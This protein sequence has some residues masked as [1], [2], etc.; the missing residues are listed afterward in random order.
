M[1]TCEGPDCDVE[2][3]P[4]RSTAKFCSATCRK[5]A[6]R[7]RG[8][9]AAPAEDEAPGA[10][11]GLTA[12]VR[13]E[14]IK[15]GALDTFYG[16]LAVQLARRL[17]YPDE[18]GISALSKELRTVMDAAVKSVP[19]PAPEAASHDAEDEVTKARRQR[20]ESRK[21]AGLA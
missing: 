18:S 12:S 8:A 16:Q 19:E 11:D 7:N 20:E 9:E 15:A 14:L 17:T 1:K 4:A 3:E 2:F 6:A 10:D 21:A 13:A 5:R